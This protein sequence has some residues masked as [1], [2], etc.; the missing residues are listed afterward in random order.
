MLVI[1]G[2]SLKN[3]LLFIVCGIL[4]ALTIVSISIIYSS[5]S[6]WFGKTEIISD[7]MNNLMINFSIYPEGIF[8]GLIRFMFYTILPLGIATYIPV[9]IISDFNIINFIYMLIGTAIFITLAF[10]IF[11][12]GLKRYSSSNLMNVRV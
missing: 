1:F 6:F 2:L 10:T 3:I 7:T 12:K 4:G 11:H 8:S 9:Q 5:L